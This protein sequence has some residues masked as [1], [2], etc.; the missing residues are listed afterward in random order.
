MEIREM[1]MSDIESVKRLMIDMF[2]VERWNDV[3]TDDKLHAYVRELMG[4]EKSLS[5]DVHSD[6]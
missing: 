6:D 4:N 2:S 1:N 3:W 5:F